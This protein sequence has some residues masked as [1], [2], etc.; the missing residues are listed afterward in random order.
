MSIRVELNP[1]QL[2]GAE[3]AQQLYEK[4]AQKPATAGFTNSI[5]PVLVGGIS[6]FQASI[7]STNTELTVIIPYKDKVFIVAP[8]HELSSIKVASEALEL[9]YQVLNT[10]K[11][12]ILQ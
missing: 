1:K 2:Q 7:P 12:G 6:A 11:F 3:I 5:Q 4:S 8:V 10:M 9:F